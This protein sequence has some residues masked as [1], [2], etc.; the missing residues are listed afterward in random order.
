VGY[1]FVDHTAELQLELEAPTKEQVLQQAVL[2]LAELLGD[3][4]NGRAEPVSRK[5]AVSAEDDA[6]LLAAWIDEVV[7]VAESEG[8]VPLRAGCVE[9]GEGVARGIVTFARVAAP[10]LVKGVTYHDLVLAPAGRGWRGRAV[11]DV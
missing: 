4:E 3:A 7:F 10:H 6:A 5:L 1:R 2:A 9:T 11:L 8:L